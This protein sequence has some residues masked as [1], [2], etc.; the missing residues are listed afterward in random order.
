MANG[1]PSVSDPALE[2][3]PLSGSV[4][5]ALATEDD[6]LALADAYCRNRDYLQPWEPIRPDSFYTA[7]GQR[8]LL[9]SAALEREAGRSLV[10]VLHDGEQVVGRIALSD[11]VRGAFQNGNLGYWVA[12]D[13]QGRGLAT[14]AVQH[15]CHVAATMGLH[16]LAAGTLLVNAGSQAVL[17]RCGF[18]EIGVAKKYLLINGQW[19]DHLLFQRILAD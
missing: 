19:Q 12:Q 18:T 1:S 5:I 2:R 16:R 17:A 15:A 10:W 14:A 8:A 6:A 4:T 3:A 7:A 9:A 13:Y 11:V